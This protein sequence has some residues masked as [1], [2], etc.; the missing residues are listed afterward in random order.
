MKLTRCNLHWSLK[1]YAQESSKPDHKLRLS[2][3]NDVFVKLMDICSVNTSSTSDDEIIERILDLELVKLSFDSQS[4]K[5]I[6]IQVV[7]I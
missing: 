6:D 5:L 7:H 2:V 1:L 4:N 3:Y